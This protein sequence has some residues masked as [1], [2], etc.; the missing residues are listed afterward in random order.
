MK[1]PIELT[2]MSEVKEITLPKNKKN[3]AGE[4]QTLK[5]VVISPTSLSSCS[6]FLILSY[7]I[8]WGFSPSC[9]L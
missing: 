3:K 8:L 2:T 9:Y 5:N 7:S 4:S 1:L 6:F